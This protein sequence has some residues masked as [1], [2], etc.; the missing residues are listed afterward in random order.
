[1]PLLVFDMIEGRAPQTVRKIL[2]CT[3]Q[4]V[5]EVFGVPTRDRYQIVHE[6]KDYQMVVEDTGLGYQRSN[7]VIILRVFTSPRSTEQKHLFM[8]RLC[9]DLQQQ[10]AIAPQ[11]LMI[12]FFTNTQDDWSFGE[13]EAQYSTGRLGG[14]PA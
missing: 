10:C 8:K 11:D 4:V 2:D 6:N 13:G 1:M 5:L 9:E 3:H 12:S 7:D 14:K